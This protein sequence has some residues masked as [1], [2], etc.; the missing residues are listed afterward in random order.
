LQLSR[1]DETGDMLLSGMGQSHIE[2]A[3]EKVKRRYKVNVL[4]KAPK[5]PY[6]ETI[7]GKAEVQGRHKKQTGGRGQF[8]DCWIRVEPRGRGEGYEFVDAIVG[9]SIPETTSR[10]WTRAYKRRPRAAWS[11][12]IRWSISAATVF[13]GSFHTV[14]SSEMAFKIAGA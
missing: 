5:I 13:D 14:D 6:R 1:D 10:P 8:G 2:T 11:R 3:I 12:A 7:K 4:L 9:G